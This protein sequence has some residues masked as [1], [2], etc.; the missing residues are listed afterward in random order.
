MGDQTDWEAE[1][2]DTDPTPSTEK[3][4]DGQAE[5]A[6]FEKRDE[7]PK[8][9]RDWPDG[10]AKFVT[11]ADGDDSGY[12]DGMTAQIGPQVVHHEDGSVSADGEIVDNPDDFKGEPIPLA[13]DVAKERAQPDDAPRGPS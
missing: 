8:D 10:K 6:E 5:M 13:I 7:L 9:P 4:R 2:S 11:F 1:V 3:D 12:G